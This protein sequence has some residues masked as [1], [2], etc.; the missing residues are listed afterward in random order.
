MESLRHLYS[1]QQHATGICIFYSVQRMMNTGVNLTFP[2]TAL[3]EEHLITDYI[4]LECHQ[5]RCDD[6]PQVTTNNIFLTLCFLPI[7]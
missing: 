6:A 1:H 5:W 7:Y 2:S 4:G 3:C